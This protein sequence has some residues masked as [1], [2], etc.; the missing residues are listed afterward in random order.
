[1]IVQLALFALVFALL[2]ASPPAL[3]ESNLTT[4]SQKTG[5]E[6]TLMG[7]HFR[8]TQLGWAV[9]SGGTVLKTLNG[10]QKWK[11]LASGC[12]AWAS[13]SP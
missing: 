8:D 2:P 3:A 11:K 1:M 6:V 10:G 9:G 4:A 7:V 12:K 5:T 13:P